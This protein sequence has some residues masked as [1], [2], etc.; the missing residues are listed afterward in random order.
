MVV[1]GWVWWFGCAAWLGL[2]V[3][4]FDDVVW[5]DDWAWLLFGDVG[6]AYFVEFM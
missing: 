4:G 5:L 2:W 1:D 6:S 3:Y